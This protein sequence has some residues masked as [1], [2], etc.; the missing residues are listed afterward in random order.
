M[1][2]QSTK[3]GMSVIGA[4]IVIIL[5]AGAVWLVMKISSSGNASLTTVA[6]STPVVEET[7]VYPSPLMVML[8]EQNKSKQAGTATL[9]QTGTSTVHVSLAMTGASATVAEPA[10]IHLGSCPTPGAV[11]YPLTSVVNGASETDIQTTLDGLLAQLPL[12]INVHKSEKEIKVYVAC[13]DI[14]AS[15]TTS[16][17]MPTETTVSY[18]AAGFSPKSVT[19]KVGDKVTWKSADGSPLWVASD[20]HPTHTEYD[21][22]TLKEHCAAGATP[23]FDECKRADTYSFIFTKAGSFDYHN[24]VHSTDAGTVIVTK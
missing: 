6:T 7:P 12:S 3:K 9:T 2:M 15:T 20:E 23:S 19:V 11:V 13:G 17:A 8:T 21:G 1:H 14:K 24:H 5:I 18:S 16:M 22:T 4:I 10:H